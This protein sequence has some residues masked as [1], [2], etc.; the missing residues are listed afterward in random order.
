MTDILYVPSL[1]FWRVLALRCRGY[2]HLRNFVVNIGKR[3]PA[4]AKTAHP[5]RLVLDSRLS[6]GSTIMD[7]NHPMDPKCKMVLLLT[8]F[9][10]S[11]A[12]V[13]HLGN[14]RPLCSLHMVARPRTYLLSIHVVGCRRSRNVIWIVETGCAEVWRLVCGQSSSYESCFGA[15]WWTAESR[16]NFCE[17][18][19]ILCFAWLAKVN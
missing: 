12:H 14:N 11:T 10:L 3:T 13:L 19:P 15:S 9:V 5:A 16:D 6:T 7:H 2:L 17:V 18:I 1:V 8:I 4:A